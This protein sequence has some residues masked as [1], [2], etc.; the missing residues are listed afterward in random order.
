MATAPVILSTMEDGKIV[1]GLSGVP[2]EG[3]VILV[4]YHMLLGVELIPLSSSFV[5]E[6]NIILRGMAHPML[7]EKLRE[8]KMPDVS[9]FDTMRVM[10]AVPVSATNFYRLLLSKSHILLYPGGVREALHRKVTLLLSA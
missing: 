1:K 2:S 5:F 8:G 6:K 4:G 3:P 9:A 10:G 7:F